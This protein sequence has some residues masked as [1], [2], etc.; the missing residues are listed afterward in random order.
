MCSRNKP[1]TVTDRGR[2]QLTCPACN[3]Q[4]VRHNAHTRGDTI[5]CSIQ[6]SN[7]IK[8]RRQKTLIEYTC[9]NCGKVFQRRKGY[10]GPARY[11]SRACST[12]A[13]PKGE[14]HS[15]WNGGSSERSHATRKAIED[16]LKEVDRCER[17]GSGEHL[18]GHHKKSYSSH[19]ELRAEVSNIEI[20]CIHCHVEEHPTIKK[21]M[22]SR[23]GILQK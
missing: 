7:L 18:H 14:N 20:L 17:C 13:A 12:V 9:L 1:R 6:C 15:K 2:T 11:C 21:L 3:K 19:P 4:F 23:V 10:S 22:L 16:R 8:P 5:C